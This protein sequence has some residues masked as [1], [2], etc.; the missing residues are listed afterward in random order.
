MNPTLYENV[1][2]RTG[3]DP[4]FLADTLTTDIELTDALFDLIDNSIDSARNNIIKSTYIKDEYGLPDSYE[5]YRIRVRFGSKCII[6]EDNCIGITSNVLENSAFYTGK[7]SNHEYGIGH[8]GLGLKR[9]LLKAGRSYAMITNNGESLYKSNFDINSFSS[10]HDNQLTAR[11]YTS[12][13][14]KR[15]LFIVSDLYP[16][17]IAQIGDSDWMANTINE[18]STRYSIFIRKGLKLTLTNSQKKSSDTFIIRPSV[19]NIRTDG[20]IK[21]IKD[22][23]HSHNTMCDF[24]V[25]IHDNYKFPGE[26]N[27]EAK[28]NK[29][30]TKSYGIYYIFNDRVII[31]ASKEDKHGF[32]THWHSEYG[33]FICLVHVVGK[34]PKNLPWNTAKTEVKINSPL[35]LQMRKMVEPLAQEYR[36][37]AKIL[38]NIWMETKDLPDDERKRIFLNKTIGKKLSDADIAAI[39]T[40]KGNTPLSLP[41]P[42]KLENLTKQKETGKL[43]ITAKDSKLSAKNNKNAHSKDWNTL[44]PDVFPVTENDHVLNNLIIEAT[45]LNINN[46]PHAS[47][48]LYR[49]M[50]EA[51]F[52]HFVKSNNLFISVKEHYYSKGEGLRKNH[53]DDY[54]KQQGIDLSMC[55]A[56]LTDNNNV[57][58]IESKK[59]LA[60]CSKK[61]KSHISTLNGVVHGNQFIGSD[62]SMQKIR[63]ET[64][65][66][67]EFLTLAKIDS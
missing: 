57:F 28:S 42:V 49:S 14:K 51:A 19:P 55:V 48:M 27:H 64:I 6:V 4:S 31:S 9:A 56:W 16:N 13:G 67:L 3:I 52:K 38:I 5:G 8:Y 44:I 45:S 46:A 43:I 21:V 10:E 59:K 63:N 47:C 22:G 1:K 17:V 25:G 29:K 34:D 60:L 30:L 18:L 39:S 40:K 35:F 33:G 15:T 36:R 53:S 54:K 37:Q 11:K 12:S 20:L 2:L 62:G 41:L 7:R 50:F 23:L 58:P 24:R 65:S 66:L 32:I 26:L 61:L